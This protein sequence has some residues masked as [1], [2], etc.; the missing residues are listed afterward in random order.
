MCENALDF[1]FEMF[2]TK[3]FAAKVF[4]SSSKAFRFSSTSLSFRRREEL[5]DIWKISN[6]WVTTRCFVL[7]FLRLVFQTCDGFLLLGILGIK[8]TW[9]ELGVE[10]PFA[11]DS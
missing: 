8:R 10:V 4:F 5:A 1:L 6:I 2:E 3:A 9:F 11:L 7:L